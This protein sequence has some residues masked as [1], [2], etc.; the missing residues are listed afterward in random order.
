MKEHLLYYLSLFHPVCDSFTQWHAQGSRYHGDQHLKPRPVYVH[1]WSIKGSMVWRKTPF[2]IIILL[3]CHLS[4]TQTYLKACLRFKC[5]VSWPSGK[6]W[7]WC[8]WLHTSLLPLWFM[9][10][11]NSFNLKLNRNSTG[12]HLKML[13]AGH[14]LQDGTWE[15]DHTRQTPAAAAFNNDG[16]LGKP[17]CHP[18]GPCFEFQANQ[19]LRSAWVRITLK[20]SLVSTVPR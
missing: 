13:A 16:E 20:Q 17:W 9:H 12:G 1:P 8:T 7:L 2:T 6:Q 4:G 14:R 19:S 15:M 5:N 3:L 18:L 10:T 11:V